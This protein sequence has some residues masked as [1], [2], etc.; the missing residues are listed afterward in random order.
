VSAVWSVTVHIRQAGGDHGA[1]DSHVSD[2]A[3]TVNGIRIPPSGSG[4]KDH[5]AARKAA[6]KA[7]TEMDVTTLIERAMDDDDHDV[8][9]TW[10]SAFCYVEP[11]R[12]VTG[13]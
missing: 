6:W 4:L 1:I 13:P 8:R 2:I 11:D 12:E 9:V 10:D 5:V 7:L 3:A